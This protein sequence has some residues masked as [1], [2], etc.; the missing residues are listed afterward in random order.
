MPNKT[1]RF[2]LNQYSRGESWDSTS[3]PEFGDDPDGHNDAVRHVDRHTLLI[4]EKTTDYTAE[5]YDMVLANASGGDFN[6]TLPS[7]ATDL[8]VDAKLV[9]ASGNVTI[10]PANTTSQTIDGQQNVSITNQWTSRTIVAN[11]TDYFI[12]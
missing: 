9:S 12:R 4:R 2:Q 1:T 7:P 3:D 6:V 10:L 11:A 5:N 8:Q